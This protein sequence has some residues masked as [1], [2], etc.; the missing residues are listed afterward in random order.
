MRRYPLIDPLRGIVAVWV[1]CSHTGVV[2]GTSLGDSIL[3][4]VLAR[5]TA[6]SIFFVL[7]GFL[8]YRPFVKARLA[9][10]S[11]PE[12]RPYM[13]RR[14]VRL[15]PPYWVALTVTALV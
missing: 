4:P 12:L 9:S 6:F 3:R 7:S 15:L 13:W 14:L 1:V 10:K 8:L 2:A 11:R 5:P